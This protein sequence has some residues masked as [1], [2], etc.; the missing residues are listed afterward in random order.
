MEGGGEATAESDEK[1]SGRVQRRGT[2]RQGAGVR[3]RNRGIVNST[4]L[5]PLTQ[6]APLKIDDLLKNK[7]PQVCSQGKVPCPRPCGFRRCYRENPTQGATGGPAGSADRDGTGQRRKP[8]HTGAGQPATP[9]VT[10]SDRD[11][12]AAEV[13]APIYTL[14]RCCSAHGHRDLER[15]RPREGRQ[16]GPVPWLPSPRRL[17]A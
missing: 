9:R 11:P 5:P 10:D 17:R 7:L 14:K 16:Q 4:L 1:G 8:Q 6:K 3:G 2:M 15:W 12:A 13:L